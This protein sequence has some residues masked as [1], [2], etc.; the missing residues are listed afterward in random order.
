MAP[1]ALDDEEEAVERGAAARAPQQPSA[2]APPVPVSSPS[3]QAVA[4]PAPPAPGSP[5]WRLVAPWSTTTWL[6]EGQLDAY[7]GGNA[8]G[9]RSLAAT[10]QKRWAWWEW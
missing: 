4:P 10:E 1:I 8:T 7:V 2:P 9:D 6:S 5:P 3:R